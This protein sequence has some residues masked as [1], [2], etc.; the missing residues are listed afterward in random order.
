MVRYSWLLFGGFIVLLSESRVASPALN[1]GNRVVD[2]AGQACLEGPGECTG[3]SS[4]NLARS[5]SECGN[6]GETRWAFTKIKSIELTANESRNASI[7]SEYTLDLQPKWISS[8]TWVD[9]GS[10]IMVVDPSSDT[11]FIY[12]SKGSPSELLP[13]N[14]TDNEKL[15]SSAKISASYILKLSGPKA[16]I[17]DDK[18]THVKNMLDI[19]KRGDGSLNG[20]GALYNWATTGEQLFA[21]G[22]FHQSQSSGYQIGFLRGRFEKNATSIGE[23]NFVKSFDFSPYYTLGQKYITVNDDYAFFLSMKGSAELYAANLSS[24]QALRKLKTIPA[25]YSQV[26]V[27]PQAT[28]LKDAPRIFSEIERN[29]LLAGIYGFKKMLYLLARSPSGMQTKWWLYQIDPQRDMV[30]GRLLLPT[31][32]HHITVVP[33][34]KSWFIF[35]KGPV[36]DGVQQKIESLVEIPTDWIVNISS[37]PLSDRNN[38]SLEKAI[39]TKTDKKKRA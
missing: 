1:S 16:L 13:K 7:C 5:G 35:E 15:E 26:P 24:G 9:A 20:L 23:V 11:V 22:T 17:L 25:E 2:F 3:G 36:E 4:P 38:K 29:N 39:C 37:S 30:I 31:V 14:L 8:A 32:A 21:I 10:R 28:S 19:G 33:S 27:L 6:I 34:P 18:L 12:S